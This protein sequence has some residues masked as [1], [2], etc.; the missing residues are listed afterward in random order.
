MSNDN[1]LNQQDEQDLDEAMSPAA[2]LEALKLRADRMGVKYHPSI[3][4]EK[5]AEKVNAALKDEV[6][7][8]E[9]KDDKANKAGDA[10]GKP[11]TENQ[12]RTRL[13]REALALVRIRVTCMN[14]AKREWEGELFTAGNSM[15]GSITKYVPFNNDEGWH[16]P[17]IIL[18]QIK[19]RECQIF[20]TVRDNRGNQVRKAK[21]IKEFA[22]EELPPLTPEELAE[23]ARRQAMSKAID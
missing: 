15:V 5:L 6:P 13:K 14:P 7:K 2:A 11:E 12:K 21:L 18:N 22:V 3:S 10:S 1:D 8:A 9:T 20:T 23:L 17:R 16:V 4:Y 19:D